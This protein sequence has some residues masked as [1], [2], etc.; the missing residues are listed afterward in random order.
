MRS[1][2]HTSAN[3]LYYV[4]HGQC[5][6]ITVRKEVEELIEDIEVHLGDNRRGER[7]RTGV[8]VVI[9]GS[10]NVGKSTL[11]NYICMSAFYFYFSQ[12]LCHAELIRI[13]MHL[14]S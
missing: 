6:M 13:L 10:P 11:L 2:Y 14:C 12:H 3:F 4:N 8:Q 1:T 5:V 7:L 9:V